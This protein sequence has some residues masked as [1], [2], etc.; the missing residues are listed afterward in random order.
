MV[1]RSLAPYDWQRLSTEMLARQ[2]VGALDKQWLQH[3]LT[4]VYATTVLQ[5]KWNWPGR[6]DDRVRALGG[7]P[8]ALA[9]PARHRP[10]G[11]RGP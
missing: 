10:S 4:L 2:L 7:A 6:D 3:A 9:D 8:V 5:M 1:R 11:D